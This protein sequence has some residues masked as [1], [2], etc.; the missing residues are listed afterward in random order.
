MSDRSKLIRRSVIAV[1]IAASL[2]ASH[3]QAQRAS[4]RLPHVAS[5]LAHH[6][7]LRIVAFGSSSTEGVGATTPQA[8]YPSQLAVDLQKRL[9]SDESIQVVNR[10]VGGDDADDM[11]ARLARDVMAAHPDLVIWQT[12]SNDP[13]RHMPLAR[14][15]A[16]TK[17]GIEAMRR[18]GIDV[19]LMGPQ[20]CEV[21]KG[22]AEPEFRSAIEAIG[23]SLHI[24][25]IDRYD[26]MRQ[27][28]ADGVLT[29]TQMLAPDGLHMADQ[30]YA[31]LADSVAADILTE[32]GEAKLSKQQAASSHL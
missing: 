24:P 17:Q 7:S 22:T 19:V 1:F 14:F 11:T 26:L 30:G 3:A 18:A 10:G 16:E 28:L 20:Y 4:V 2:H 5:V 25:V 13:L 32:A 6:R 9:P 27:W 23:A 29:R 15:I 21:L 31:R 8:A 12:G